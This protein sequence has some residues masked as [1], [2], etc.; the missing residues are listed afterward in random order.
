MSQGEAN[1]KMLDATVLAHS[2]TVSLLRE[3][4]D[5]LVLAFE[6]EKA[7]KPSPAMQRQKTGRKG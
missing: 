3:I 7:R 1:Q 6:A 4:R 2:E 5:L